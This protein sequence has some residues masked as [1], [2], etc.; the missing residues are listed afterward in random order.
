MTEDG[1]ILGLRMQREVDEWITADQKEWG[2]EIKKMPQ[3][4]LDAYRD[5]LKSVHNDQAGRNWAIA[6]FGSCF[7]PT[8]AGGVIGLIADVGGGVNDFMSDTIAD[9]EKYDS[10]GEEV[11]ATIFDAAFDFP[12]TEFSVKTDIADILIDTLDLIP[13]AGYVVSTAVSLL[14]WIEAQVYS[15]GVDAGRSVIEALGIKEWYVRTIGDLINQACKKADSSFDPY[16]QQ[17]M[18]AHPASSGVGGSW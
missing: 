13:G 7:V 5:Q 4:Y 6:S 17:I 11:A 15:L 14:L 10:F 9:W 3:G 18:T 16:L 12:K 1:R 8:W 2:L